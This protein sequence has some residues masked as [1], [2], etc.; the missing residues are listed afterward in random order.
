[1]GLAQCRSVP[2]NRR[3]RRSWPLAWRGLRY[4]CRSKLGPSGRAIDC[5]P[6]PLVLLG[7]ILTHTQTCV[8]RDGRCSGG[9]GEVDGGGGRVTLSKN[10]Q[11]VYYHQGTSCF[12]YHSPPR[13][14]KYLISRE[15]WPTPAAAP[16]PSSLSQCGRRR[17]YCFCARNDAQPAHSLCETH[18]PLTL[19]EL[20]GSGTGA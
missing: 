9:S 8:T 20:E 18:V 15:R 10:T 6:S 14:R 12:E 5:W 19:P 11:L 16:R 17:W 13:P 1:M 7:R 2:G 3:G 4:Y